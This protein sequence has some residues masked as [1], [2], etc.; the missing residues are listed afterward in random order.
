MISI[1]FL[2]FKV[3]VQIVHIEELTKGASQKSGSPIEKDLLNSY[4]VNHSHLVN[5][6]TF[7]GHLLCCGRTLTNLT[8]LNY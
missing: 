6:K 4:L 2:R 7:M 3:R 5:Q 8:E 1:T